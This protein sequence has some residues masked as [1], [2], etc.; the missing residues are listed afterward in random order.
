MS[1]ETIIS[2]I[3]LLLVA[4]WS[5]VHESKPKDKPKEDDFDRFITKAIVVFLAI[6]FLMSL[7]GLF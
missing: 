2:A 1:F 6:I 4:F 7:L 3:L 5:L